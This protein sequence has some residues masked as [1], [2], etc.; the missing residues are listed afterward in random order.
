MREVFEMRFHVCQSVDGLERVLKSRKGTVHGLTIDGKQATRGQLIEAIK[1][2]RSNGY[3]VFPP[4]D[5]YNTKGHCQGHDD[6]V[7]P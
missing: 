3:E 1:V 5:N 2:A 7:T 6:E 4:C